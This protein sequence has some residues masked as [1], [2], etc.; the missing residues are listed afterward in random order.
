MVNALVMAASFEFVG[1]FLIGIAVLLTHRRI[2]QEHR[3][4]KKVLKEI[5]HERWVSILGLALI[6]VGF[7]INIRAL[8]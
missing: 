1:T 3:I 7:I 4:D 8:T 5:R 2:R 6:A